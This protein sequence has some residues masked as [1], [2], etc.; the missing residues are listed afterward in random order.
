MDA[1]TLAGILK[2]SIDS[3]EAETFRLSRDQL[4]EIIEV[5]YETVELVG[6]SIPPWTPG[7]G[8]NKDFLRAATPPNGEEQT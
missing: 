4:E 8:P 1:K 5:L 7:R 2:K 3:S 6:E